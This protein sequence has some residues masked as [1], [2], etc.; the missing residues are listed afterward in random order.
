MGKE[1]GMSPPQDKKKTTCQRQISFFRGTNN[2]HDVRSIQKKPPKNKP[3][4]LWLPKMFE[5]GVKKSVS[6]CKTL[7][8]IIDR[9]VRKFLSCH[10][11]LCVINPDPAT[12]T[13]AKHCYVW[14]IINTVF[15]FYRYEPII[16]IGFLFEFF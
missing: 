8:Q 2:Q 4:V 11:A 9:S 1:G 16:N 10:L 3:C 12:K 13:K 5:L 7:L 6:F 15:L 14:P